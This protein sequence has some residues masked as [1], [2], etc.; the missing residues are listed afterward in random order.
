[1]GKVTNNNKSQNDEVESR[2]VFYRGGVARSSD[3]VAVM[4]M[5]QRGNIIL[6]DTENNWGT[7]RIGWARANNTRYPKR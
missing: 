3:E 1:M 4:A 2:K 7:R 5:E 6:L